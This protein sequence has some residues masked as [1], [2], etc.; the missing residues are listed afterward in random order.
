MQSS[1][2]MKPSLSPG[3][4]LQMRMA[5]M[6]IFK[7]TKNRNTWTLIYGEDSAEILRCLE[8]ERSQGYRTEMEPEEYGDDVFHKRV[9]IKEGCEGRSK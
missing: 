5:F 3:L 7:N 6:N 1:T 8:D 4:S 2:V 9:L